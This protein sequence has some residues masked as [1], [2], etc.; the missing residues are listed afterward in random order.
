MEIPPGDIVEGNIAL[1]RH[2][3][4]I[5][6]LKLYSFCCLTSHI[7]KSNRI[8]LLFFHDHVMQ[9]KDARLKPLL[10]DLLRLLTLVASRLCNLFGL[11]SQ[12]KIPLP[13]AAEVSR[14]KMGFLKDF[15]G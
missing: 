13:Y 7:G 6:F 14:D 9:T 2:L 4:E 5:T 3:L 10:V 12:F 15:F 1:F 11:E 8:I